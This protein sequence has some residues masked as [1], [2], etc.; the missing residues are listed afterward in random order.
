MNVENETNERQK[1]AITTCSYNS[2][3]WRTH[4]I[5]EQKLLLCH[6]S[7]WKLVH[8]VQELST[9]LNERT[10]RTKESI[11][12][13]IG[14]KLSIKHICASPHSGLSI[15]WDLRPLA[16]SESFM[17]SFQEGGGGEAG[18]GV[19][20]THECRF[21]SW[22][23]NVTDLEFSL[24]RWELLWSGARGIVYCSCRAMHFASTGLILEANLESL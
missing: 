20:Y 7:E 15:K 4:G 2:T 24:G 22:G 13:Y 3:T 17:F 12:K 16:I 8:C 10:T 21:T 1:S 19:Q 14:A 5:K 6:F 23:C 9:K 11:L 18:V